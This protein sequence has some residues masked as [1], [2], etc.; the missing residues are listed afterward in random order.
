[1]AGAHGLASLLGFVL[2]LVGQTVKGRNGNDG[3]SHGGGSGEEQVHM[4]K[5]T[6]HKFMNFRLDHHLHVNINFT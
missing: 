4:P 3:H 1:V 5:M 6:R 2:S